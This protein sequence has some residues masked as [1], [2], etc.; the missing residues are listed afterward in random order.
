MVGLLTTL[1][2]VALE[3]VD[4]LDCCMSKGYGIYPFT[5]LKITFYQTQVVV[6]GTKKKVSRPL[7]TKCEYLE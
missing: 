4:F 7:P 5:F 2:T 3:L 1:V 6:V